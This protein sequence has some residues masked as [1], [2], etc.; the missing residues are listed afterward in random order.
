MRLCQQGDRTCA[1]KTMGK[2]PGFPKDRKVDT[3]LEP[4]TTIL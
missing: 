1:S 2:F 4:E 3:Y